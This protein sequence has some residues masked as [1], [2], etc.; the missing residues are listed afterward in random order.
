MAGTKWMD[1]GGGAEVPELFH[2]ISEQEA[3]NL[4]LV[5]RAREA[6]N[7]KFVRAEHPGSDDFIFSTHRTNL[8]LTGEPLTEADVERMESEE[9][10]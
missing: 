3:Y 5:S 8:A 6:L 4:N 7:K 2:W 10:K 9:L 1:R